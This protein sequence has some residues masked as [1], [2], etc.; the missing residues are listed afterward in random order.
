MDRPSNTVTVQQVL[1]GVSHILLFLRCHAPLA[2]FQGTPCGATQDKPVSLVA[3][4]V[5]DRGT[6]PS[7][8]ALRLVSKVCSRGFSL[9]GFIP[10]GV[11][12]RPTFATI[13]R[14]TLVPPDQGEWVDRNRLVPKSPCQLEHDKGWTGGQIMFPPHAANKNEM[15]TRRAQPARV[16]QLF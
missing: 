8:G 2:Q 15:A 16:V 13:L 4:I 1:Q 12:L 6:A 3:Y 10:L 7:S 9:W 5:Q 11:A 14:R